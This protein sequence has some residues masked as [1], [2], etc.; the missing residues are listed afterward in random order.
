[1]NG[2]IGLEGIE[3]RYLE[4]AT[5]GRVRIDVAEMGK[6]GV[7]FQ[8]AENTETVTRDGI[9]GGGRKR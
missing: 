4:C 5:L 2:W 7:I 1:M 6:A 9:L 8:I 3:A